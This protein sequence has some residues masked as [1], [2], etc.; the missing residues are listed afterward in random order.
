MIEAQITYIVD[1]ITRLRSDRVHRFEVRR[2][3]QDAFVEDVHA[4]SQHGTWLNGGCSSYY[5][6]AAG[7]NSGL[8]PNWS[9]EYRRRTRRFDAH[10]YEMST[11]RTTAK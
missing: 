6:N 10:N 9:F 1:A 8:Y 11:E 4:R 5:T 2:E 7:M 3:V